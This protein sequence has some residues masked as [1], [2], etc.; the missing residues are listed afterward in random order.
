MKMKN[1]NEKSKHNT[2]TAKEFFSQFSKKDLLKIRVLT[3]V[4][5]KE[6]ETTK[7]FT[8]EEREERI[9]E[10]HN[11]MGDFDGEPISY[12]D[13]SDY[14]LRINF[15]RVPVGIIPDEFEKLLQKIGGAFR[16]FDST[17][18]PYNPRDDAYYIGITSKGNFE[19][20]HQRLNQFLVH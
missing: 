13:N 2:Q 19:F 9:S 20:F 3:D 5:K 17:T 8:N 6:L 14:V 4:I 7:R 10:L 11:I 1:D 12:Y 16:F 18:T 15:G